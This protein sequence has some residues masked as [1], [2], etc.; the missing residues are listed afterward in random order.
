[1]SACWL[2]PYFL[3]K[4]ATSEKA[5]HAAFP[6]RCQDS[7]S[8]LKDKLVP[9]VHAPKERLRL[10]FHGRALG[11]DQETLEHAGGY[12]WGH[13]KPKTIVF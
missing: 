2:P 7:V 1:M 5:V 4:R 6:V 13:T 12:A 10:I 11:D 8:D 3:E 9:L